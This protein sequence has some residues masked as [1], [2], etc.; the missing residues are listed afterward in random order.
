MLLL[1]AYGEVTPWDVDAIDPDLADEKIGAM[2]DLAAADD[3]HPQVISVRQR[4]D[5]RVPSVVGA[6]RRRRSRP[7]TTR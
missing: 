4:R 3:P 2:A 1:D 5:Y 7:G 6:D